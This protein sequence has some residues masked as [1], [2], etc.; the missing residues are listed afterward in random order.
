MKAII[1][2]GGYGKRLRPLTD[3]RPK[4]MIEVLNTPIIEWQIRWFK[5][6]GTKEMVICVGY[7]KEQ[8]IDYIGSGTRF[9]VKVGYAVE[10][11]PLGTGGALKNAESLLG[12]VA[13][14]GF[15]MVNGDILTD[16]DPNKLRN[17]NTAS[18]ALVPLRSPY[19]VV[20]VDDHSKVTGFLEKPVIK[21]KWINAG[22]Y[23]FTRDVF[24]LLPENGNIEITA[25]PNLVK[26]NKLQG[27]RY[28]NS[29]WRSIDS[30]KDIEDA[31]KEIESAAIV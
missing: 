4:P 8:I 6:H 7:L 13:D 27:I 11:E 24:H 1:L 17:T 9:G 30:H 16:L 20:E 2:A 29:F 25:L 23:H 18:L 3:E 28:A 19:G 31:T 21:D 14:D 26:I 15:F 22:V 10:E 5:K 12:G